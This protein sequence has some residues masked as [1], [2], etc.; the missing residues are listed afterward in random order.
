MEWKKIVMMMKNK[1]K[2]NNVFLAVVTVALPTMLEQI[3]SV[4]MQYVDTAMVGRLGA[5]ATAAASTTITWLIGSMPYAFG[6]A[7]MTLIAQAIGSG[8]ESQIKQ[9][10]KECLLFALGVGAVIEVLCFAVTPFIATWMGAEESIRPAATRYFFWISVPVILKSVQYILASAIRATK[11]TTTPMIISIVINAVNLG[12]DYIFIYIFGLGVDG[13]AYATC[14]SAALGGILTLIVFFRNPYLGFK[15]SLFK[16]DKDV[17]KRMWVLSLPVLLI[18]VASTSGYVVFAGL[19][20]HMGTIIFAA[21]SIAVGAEELF[22]IGGYGFKSAANTMVGIAY[23]EQNHKK[24]HD[25]CVSSVVCTLAVMT[26]S[27]ILLFIFAEPL[28]GFF[29]KDPSVIALG[30]TVL[31]MVAF[32][33]PFFGMYVISEGIYYGLGETKYPFIIEFGGMWLVRILATYIGLRFFNQGLIYVWCCMIADNVIKAILLTVPLPGL[34][35]K[36]LQK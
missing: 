30:V 32:S 21:H 33:E 4:L 6:V 7:A 31:K 12:L 24:Y 14:I 36:T 9:V 8:K 20:S 25:V 11:D 5:D 10:A 19:V 18:N 23:G 34:W 2:I 15:D 35:K 13:A 27:G 16:T 29:T 17:T 1:S 22:Y 26:L 28:M 3:L